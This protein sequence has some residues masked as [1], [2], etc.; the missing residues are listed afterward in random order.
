MR[1]DVTYR[2]TPP[3]TYFD[4]WSG[5]LTKTRTTFKQRD[6]HETV[7]IALGTPV[8]ALFFWIYAHTTVGKY[9]K[10]VQ[11]LVHSDY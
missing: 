4:H 3:I 10:P 9:E 8:A 5:R 7:P 11:L 6:L 2:S 1:E